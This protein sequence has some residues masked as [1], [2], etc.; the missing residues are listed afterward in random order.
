MTAFWRSWKN[1]LLSF[2]LIPK[3]HQ[4][5][6]L[7]NAE[8][9]HRLRRK[10]IILD[11][12][13]AFSLAD[14]NAPPSLISFHR[15]LILIVGRRGRRQKARGFPA[16]GTI[17]TYSGIWAE[18]NAKDWEVKRLLQKFV[19]VVHRSRYMEW[20]GIAGEFNQYLSSILF[21]FYFPTL[22][23]HPI[24]PSLTA[25]SSERPFWFAAILCILQPDLLI[26]TTIYFARSAVYSLSAWIFSEASTL[27][28]ST[29][30]GSYCAISRVSS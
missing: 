3:D 28:I 10:S 5:R 24:C 15:V 8:L 12:N 16:S 7:D 27:L 23:K 17:Q 20:R 21:V 1:K 4:Y 29:W 26:Y 11:I 2:E 19:T 22:C 30:I 13:V 9:A 14:S 18:F 25:D 6:K